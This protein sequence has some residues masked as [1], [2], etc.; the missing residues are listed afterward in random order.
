MLAEH[1]AL[2]EGSTIFIFSNSG[3]NAVTVEMAIEAKKRG[4]TVIAITNMI[5]TSA[6]SSRHSSGKKLCDI[7]DIVIDNH[8]CYGDA[9]MEI[10]KLRVSPTSTSVGAAILQSV[11]CGVV[12]TAEENGVDIPVFS[13]S[14]ID[15]G[16][17]VNE[18]H[19]KNFT[20]KVRPLW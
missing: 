7:A 9:S 8:G 17:A 4:L 18:A 20:D 12:K 6:A 15:G 2:K 13:S 5:H 16:D 11:V 19:I 10:G 3:R 14:N 1:Y